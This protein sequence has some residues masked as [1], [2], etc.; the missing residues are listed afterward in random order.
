MPTL[1]IH[2]PISPTPS[3]FTMVGCFAA[4]LRAF[5]GR[6][7]NARV[8]VSVGEDC[9]PFDIAAARPELARYDITWRWTDR[10][11]FRKATYF[12][13]GLDRW[14]EEFDCDYVLMA[15]AD[16]V[17]LNSFEDVLAYL[18]DERSVAGVIATFPPFLG[19]DAGDDRVRWP[20][21]YAY[22]GLPLPAFRFPIPGYGLLYPKEA[23]S[24]APPYY[25]FGFVFG[26]REAM[27]AIRTTFEADYGAALEYMQTDLSA[28]AGLCLSIERNRIRA[29]ALPV[30]FNFWSNSIYVA[31]FSD[32]L[33][34][35]RVM[36]YLGPPF[37]K[38]VDNHTPEQLAQWIADNATSD[39]PTTQ[40]LCS[41]FA[42]VLGEFRPDL[43]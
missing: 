22:A 13:T 15:D 17:V 40:L 31:N 9:D 1:Q 11:A 33:R 43:V 37:R 34:D 30:R 38:H 12:A 7:S 4:S 20:E 6:F 42:K 27:N 25:N 35:I 36:H 32:D 14:A 26:T 18:P 24:L 19:R 23:M 21:L 16:M 10:E 5:G 41:A 29:A 28:Q 8:V 2:I 39:D 3:F